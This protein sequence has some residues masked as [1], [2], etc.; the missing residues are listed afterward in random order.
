[1]SISNHPLDH[2]FTVIHERQRVAAGAD[3]GHQAIRQHQGSHYT[4]RQVSGG[5]TASSI[6]GIIIPLRRL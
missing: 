4:S 6:G 3:A 2:V 5:S 1:V